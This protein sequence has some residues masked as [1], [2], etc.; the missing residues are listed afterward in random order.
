MINITEWLRIL[1]FTF[2]NKWDQVNRLR[3]NS[4]LR[5]GN[6]ELLAVFVRQVTINSRFPV[7]DPSSHLA[8]L[9]AS[10]SIPPFSVWWSI[11]YW[12]HTRNSWSPLSFP[13][14]TGL[15]LEFIPIQVNDKGRSR[16]KKWAMWQ[17]LAVTVPM[18]TSGTITIHWGCQYRSSHSHL[19]AIKCHR[20]TLHET[21]FRLWSFH[22]YLLYWLLSTTRVNR[23]TVPFTFFLLTTDW[24]LDFNSI[25]GVIDSSPSFEE[26]STYY[27]LHRPYGR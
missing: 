1:I 22:G 12:A 13:N 5:R 16:S 19:A 21:Q 18:N 10:H 6:V 27:W 2:P 23:I 14:V 3:V 26:D 9:K 25:Q 11:I 24:D 4:G 8:S 7:T 15:H 17:S 20:F